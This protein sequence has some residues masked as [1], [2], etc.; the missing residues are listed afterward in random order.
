M[1]DYCPS[2]GTEVDTGTEFC[3]DCGYDFK[4]EEFM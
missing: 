1:L 4:S 3:G 2:C